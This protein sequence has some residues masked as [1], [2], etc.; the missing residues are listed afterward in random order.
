MLCVLFRLGGRRTGPRSRQLRDIKATV[1]PR[2]TAADGCLFVLC[3]QAASSGPRTTVIA[4]T[5]DT[6]VETRR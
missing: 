3:S 2:Q 6:S 1:T 4:P 5:G